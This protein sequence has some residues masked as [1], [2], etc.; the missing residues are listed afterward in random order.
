VRERRFIGIDGESYTV[1]GEH[2]YVLLAASN[3]DTVYEADGLTTVQCFHFL[4]KQRAKQKN[5]LFV[6]FGLNYDVNMMLRD[7]GRDK[8]EKLWRD[9]K[10][11]WYNYRLEWIPGKWFRVS[12]DDVSIRIYDVFGFFQKSFV[13]AL[14]SW[15]IELSEDLEEMKASRSVF[16]EA[17]RDEMISYCIGECEKLVELMNALRD[18]LADVGLQ[19]ASWVGAGSIASALLRRE[20]VHAAHRHDF[21]FPPAVTNAIL[22]SYFG[23]RV[24][25]FRQ[26]YFERLADYDVS[27]AYPS[28]A[29]ALPSMIGG[30]WKRAENY[31]SSSRYSLWHVRWNVDPDAILMPFPF[32]HKRAIFYPSQ[33]EGWYHSPEVAAA[34][35]RY[36]D[37]IEILDGWT[38]KPLTDESPFSFIRKMYDY[39]RKLKD[40]G[41]AGEKVL[42]LGLNAIYG[43]LAQ[44]HGF[45]GKLPPFQ[46]YYW[47]GRITSGTRA[48]L[49]D[50][51][52]LAPEQLVMIATDGIFFDEP[53]PH[54]ETGS[55]LGS[56]ERSVFENVFVAQAGVYY[57]VLDGEEIRRSRGFFAKE[58]DFEQLRDGYATEGP[59][60]K[61]SYHSRR[62][63]GLGSALM[64]KD[65]S[66]WRTWHDSERNLSLYPNRKFLREDA[67]QIG[68]PVRHFP[69]RFDGG[70]S[71]DIYVPKDG[72]F[73]WA[74]DALEYIEGTEQPLK[75]F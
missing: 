36:G 34:R 64:R 14:K 45:G 23:G 13:N 8:L 57:G 6:A 54:I 41:H 4:L 69:A 42:K 56:W 32:R 48:K 71:S 63:V 5:Y 3:G 52:T 19:P 33:G 72:A 44:G 20:G 51:G 22:H 53:S 46:S 47:A 35:N 75:D 49:F 67:L 50:A 60:F 61:A 73:A 58:I 40:E 16:D 70:I 7:V 37:A 30:I 43:K 10:V 25:L 55:V 31:D 38:Y 29:L 17:M 15:N 9:H 28:Q 21:E 26:G 11:N 66:L 62:F 27:S 18:A 1:D 39:R 68:A 2:R 59:Y 74:D 65:L 24:E 12:K